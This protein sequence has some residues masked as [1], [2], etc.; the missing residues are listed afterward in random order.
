MI[1]AIL[2]FVPVKYTVTANNSE[3]LYVNLNAK[4]LMSI[5]RLH[6]FLNNGASE[7][8]FTILFFKINSDKK[9]DKDK[10]YSK[11]EKSEA[12]EKKSGDTP[13][14]ADDNTDSVSSGKKDTAEPK[15]K[16]FSF[17]SVKE[18]L[19]SFKSSVADSIESFRF[20]L[21]YPDKKLILHYTI[22][23]IKELIISLKPKAFR[24]D[25]EIGFDDPALTGQI[26]GAAYMMKSLFL[27]KLDLDIKI[28]FE[29]E[30]L[31]FNTAAKGSLSLWSILFPLIKYAIRKPIRK[32][33]FSRFIK[34]KDGY[35]EH[36]SKRQS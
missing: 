28:N 1:V 15:K 6:Y 29:K 2:L 3:D 22:A 23:C 9:K 4:W 12:N 32:I 18:N 30:K 31:I 11:D 13:E 33:I 5:F 7:K 16:K 34:R 35:G 14:T 8:S 20:A 21:N 17:A 27:N 19:I 24:L 10:K 36:E 26:G 25:L